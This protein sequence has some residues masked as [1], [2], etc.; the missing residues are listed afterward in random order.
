MRKVLVVLLIAC[1]LVL[2]LSVSATAAPKTD[3]ANAWGMFHVAGTH[4]P[5]FHPF[6]Q[7]VKYVVK[8]QLILEKLTWSQINSQKLFP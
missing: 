1:V 6:G 7:T 4:N 2:A 3:P 8:P 5:D